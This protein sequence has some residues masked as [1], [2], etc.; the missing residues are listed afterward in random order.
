[1]VRAGP[2]VQGDQRPEVDDRQPVGI[3]RAVRLLGH[4]VIHHPEEAGGQEE[5]HRVVPVPPLH[6]GVGGAA[7][8]RVGLEPV[9][10]DRQVVDH[11][12]HGDDHDEGAEEP[13][14]DVQVPGLAAQQGAEEHHPVGD[15]DDA[16][17][18]RAGELD[19]GVFLG[20]GMAQRQGH[21]QDQD[22]RLPAP[23]GEGGQPVGVQPRLAGALHRVVAGGELR[24]AGEAEDHQAGVQRP[25]A[26]EAGPRQVEVQLRP[27]QLAGDQHAHGHADHAPDHG[28]DGELAHHLVVVRLCDGCTHQDLLCDGYQASASTD[29]A[30]SRQRG[31]EKTDSDEASGYGSDVRSRF[32]RVRRAHRSG[33]D[34]WVFDAALR[35]PPV[36]GAHGAPYGGVRRAPIRGMWRWGRR[37]AVRGSR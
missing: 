17:P 5:T 37:Q 21:Q 6:H 31:A 16:H 27:D 8:H 23:E 24:A 15:P 34:T 9:H 28:H 7:V 14:A 25:Q 12:E 1:M 19:L 32:C 35:W 33:A 18:Q 3:H 2:D 36:N 20:G 11:V 26:A 22:H 10:R 4:E 29:P 13:V 30:H